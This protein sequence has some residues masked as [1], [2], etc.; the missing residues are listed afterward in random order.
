MTPPS[1]E[2]PFTVACDFDPARPEVAL[3]SHGADVAVRRGVVPN[4][5]PRAQAR[6]PA[7][8]HGDGRTLIRHPGGVRFLVEGGDTVHYDASGVS[9]GDIG[10]FL[11]GSAWAALALQRGLLPLHVSAVRAPAGAVHA[12]GGTS[13]AGKS[14]LAVALGR[15][16]LAFFADDLLLVD[17]ASLGAREAARCYGSPALRLWPG[18][19]ALTGAPLGEPV[20]EGVLKRWADPAHPSP[21]AV[22]SLR[23]LHVL[24]DWDGQPWGDR[25]CAIEPLAGRR[26]LLALL[27]SLYRKRQALAIVGRERLFEWLLTA[28]THH[29]QVSMFHRPRSEQRFGQGAWALARALSTAT[30]GAA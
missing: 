27:E 4:A 24:S 11:V 10:A 25:P 29:V 16:G 7:W 18:G 15:H 6:G 3:R 2:V 13:G 1:V 17:P 14:T 21:N 8:E 20:R 30:V 12:F 5:L 26:A 19:A 9:A 28:S 23:T 22:G